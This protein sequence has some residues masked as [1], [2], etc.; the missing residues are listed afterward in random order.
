MEVQKT[1]GLENLSDEQVEAIAGGWIVDRG[2][3]SDAGGDR[4]V[5]VEDITG[6]VMGQAAD[7][8]GARNYAR[9]LAAQGERTGKAV[10]TPAEYE[11]MFG[12]PLFG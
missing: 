9:S 4:F 1:T 11:Q 10:I 5:I 8:N 7:F 3:Q 6:E 2:E 12:K